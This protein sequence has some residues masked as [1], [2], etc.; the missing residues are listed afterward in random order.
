MSIIA[1][2]DRDALVCIHEATKGHR[3]HRKCNWMSEKRLN[4]WDGVTVELSGHVISLTLNDNRLE[5]FVPNSI[6]MKG[7][8]NLKSLSLSANLLS[9]QVS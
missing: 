7:L 1:S 2:N 5:G 9:H 8:V 6:R 3:W 4:K